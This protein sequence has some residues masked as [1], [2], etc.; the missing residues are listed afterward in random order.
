MFTPEEQTVHILTDTLNFGYDYSCQ[1]TDSHFLHCHNFYE[2]YFF[3]EG[4]VDYLVE[5]QKYKPAPNSLLLLAPHAFH[6]VKI[7]SDT[8]YRRCSL[9]F[10]PDILSPERRSFLLSSFP[11][12]EKNPAQKIYYEHTERFG[13]PVYFDALKRCADRAETTKEQQLPICVEALLSQIVSMCEID[14]PSAK[15]VSPDT[16]SRIIWYLNRHL[17]DD[18]SLDQ[19]SERFFISKHHLNKVFKKATGTTVF[20]YLLHKRVIAAQQLLITGSSAQNAALASGFKDYSAFYRSYTRILGHSPLQ[21]RGVLPSL[22]V[23]NP[24][25]LEAFTLTSDNVQR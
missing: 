3:L 5:G 12:P 16:V 9:H 22:A 18:I 15:A 25:G 19:I 1:K 14:S 2:V 20:D 23:S 11:S 24:K 21:D 13:L 7:N 4:D 17:G 10:H 6:G 8:P